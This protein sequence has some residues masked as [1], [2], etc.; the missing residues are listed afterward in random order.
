MSR[1]SEFSEKPRIKLEDIFS[2]QKKG[3][4]S[5]FQFEKL[6]ARRGFL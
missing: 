2:I 5:F 4:F 6:G 3:N 1:Y